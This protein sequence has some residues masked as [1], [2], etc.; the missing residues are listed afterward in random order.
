M[1]YKSNIYKHDSV[2]AN[3]KVCSVFKTDELCSFVFAFKLD[4]LSFRSIN[5]DFIFFETKI[6]ESYIKLATCHPESGS[7]PEASSAAK[8]NH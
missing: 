2:N 6:M 1:F 5:F 4:E 3:C 8:K 7:L